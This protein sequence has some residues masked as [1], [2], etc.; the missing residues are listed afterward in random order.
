MKDHAT[1]YLL[2]AC[3]FELSTCV[4]LLLLCRFYFQSKAAL[5][6]QFPQSEHSQADDDDDD[7]GDL[8]HEDSNRNKN[9]NNNDRKNNDNYNEDIIRY[10]RLA[11][12]ATL[13]FAFMCLFEGARHTFLFTRALDHPPDMPGKD[14]PLTKDYSRKDRISF[15]FDLCTVLCR[16]VLILTV[17]FFQIWRL[18]EAFDGNTRRP[19]AKCPMIVLK[20]LSVLGSI[21]SIIGVV[22][23]QYYYNH[24]HFAV[25]Y[26]CGFL[27]YIIFVIIP[28]II[29][30]LFYK[31]LKFVA[32]DYMKAREKLENKINYS[33]DIIT[34][35]TAAASD[36]SSFTDGISTRS[37]TV[38][39]MYASDAEAGGGYVVIFPDQRDKYFELMAKQTLLAIWEA[40]AMCIGMLM[41]AFAYL[42]LYI[43]K[44]YPIYYQFYPCGIFLFCVNGIIIILCLWFSFSFTNKDYH[45]VCKYCHFKLLI[46]CRRRAENE[47]RS[48]RRGG[49]KGRSINVINMNYSSSTNG[50]NAKLLNEDDNSIPNIILDNEIN[51]MGG[52]EL[53]IGSNDTVN[54]S[55]TS[56]RGF[57]NEDLLNDND[58]HESDAFVEKIDGY[59]SA[60]GHPS[61]HYK[62]MES[63]VFVG[64][65]VANSLSVP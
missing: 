5:D 20:I 6:L 57:D 56:N 48:N 58:V 50:A 39:D 53:R 42:L 35:A 41:L 47:I 34:A 4:T 46:K 21:A 19:I 55:I 8:Y 23:G 26:I 36:D 43:K 10:R 9:N 44:N 52:Q 24:F 45:N 25:Y 62:S 63:N 65:N 49:S 18:E 11:I 60:Q 14:T 37:T 16:G 29:A 3:F 51:I 28:I 61:G 22:V 17:T 38:D 13:C 15:G 32:V 31:H 59:D 27:A 33:N 2:C 30:R 1:V 40:F 64:N 54:T 12:G 7:D